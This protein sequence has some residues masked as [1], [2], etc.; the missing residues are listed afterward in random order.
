MRATGSCSNTIVTSISLISEG[1]PPFIMLPRCGRTQLLEELCQRGADIN[2]K[3][4]K[5]FT[6]LINSI[7]EEKINC[8][9]VL[10]RFGSELKSLQ[11]HS[12][13]IH[14]SIMQHSMRQNNTARME[15]MYTLLL[16]AGL[17]INSHLPCDL[18]CQETKKITSVP[19]LM[20]C[21]RVAVRQ[22]VAKH[23]QRTN[24]F[25]SVENLPLPQRIKNFLLY[26]VDLSK[27]DETE[28]DFN[29]RSVIQL[30]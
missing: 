25:I 27:T 26:N 5:G 30:A 20:H 13:E 15:T 11:R 12:N 22:N 29:V 3:S 24:L 10:L 28:S 2:L 1:I 19:S 21:S 23:N 9:K 6:P 17:R 16:V 4:A 8:I 7:Q 18:Q 14:Q